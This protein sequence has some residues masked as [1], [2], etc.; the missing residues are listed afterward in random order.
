M[1]FHYLVT[2]DYDI[3]S[4]K[5]LSDQLDKHG[6]TSMLLTYTSNEKD[7]LIKAAYTLDPNKKIKYTIALRTYAISPEYVAMIYNS[8]EDIAKN[9][10]QFNI[11]SGDV[12][13]SEDVLA[14]TVNMEN[15]VNSTWGRI[16][17]TEKWLES[18][19]KLNTLSSKPY[20]WMSGKSDKT[21]ELANKYADMF[22]GEKSD[23]VQHPW[24]E[25]DTYN[26]TTDHRGVLFGCIVRETEEEAKDIYDKILKEYNN[27]LSVTLYGTEASVS[28]QIEDFCEKNR[29]TDIM[30]INWGQDEEFDRVNKMVLNIT[31]CD[32]I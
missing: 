18:F 1:R 22:I 2:K 13:A 31:E 24:L 19:N 8:F 15:I 5:D 7:G 26:I 23:Y 12:G 30:F 29:I 17:Y 32:I 3:K 9:K 10:L 11:I 27:N 21:K 16:M 14:G 4:F 20:I 6:Y 25:E 28:K